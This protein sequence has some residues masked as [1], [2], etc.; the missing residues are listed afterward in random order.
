VVIITEVHTY[1]RYTIKLMLNGVLYSNAFYVAYLHELT[2][3][4]LRP[5]DEA[6]GPQKSGILLFALVYPM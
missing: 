3:G 6:A 5:C 4:F 1:Q 2:L